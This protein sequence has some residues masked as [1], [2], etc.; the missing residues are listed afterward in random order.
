M[1]SFCRRLMALVCSLMSAV[2]CLLFAG[3]CWFSVCVFVCCLLMCVC[4]LFV[5]GVHVVCFVC[6]GVVVRFRRSLVVV[7]CALMFVVCCRLLCFAR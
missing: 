2:G 5:V 3:W 6:L 7:C 4:G 1:L